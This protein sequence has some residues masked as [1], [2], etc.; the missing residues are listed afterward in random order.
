MPSGEIAIAGKLARSVALVGVHRRRIASAAV[1]RADH[2]RPL[3]VGARRSSDQVIRIWSVASAPDGAPLAMSMLGKVL[4]R[5]PAMPSMVNRPCAGSNCP[6]PATGCTIARGR[7]N[8]RA[9]VERAGLEE[10]ALA[11]HDVGADP[12]DVHHAVAVG[13]D[14]AALAAA[15]LAVVGRRGQLAR[16]PGVTAVG[17]PGEQHRLGSGRAPERR[18]CTR[19]RCRSAG[20]TRRCR[21]RAVP[22]R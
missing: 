14:R 22:C 3:V 17:G 1:C 12:D 10:H 20:S 7:S 11:R 4:V 5:A 2:E 9:S 19:T 15:G 8:V 21:P 18:R 16:S 13:A 6:M